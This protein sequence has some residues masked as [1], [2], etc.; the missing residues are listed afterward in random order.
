MAL[1]PRPLSLLR[2]RLP[3]A[4][5]GPRLGHTCSSIIYDVGN[6]NVDEKELQAKLRHEESGCGAITGRGFNG[7]IN[8]F[9]AAKF[10]LPTVLKAGCVERAI[11]SAG[12]PSIH[13]KSHGTHIFDGRDSVQDV[14]NSL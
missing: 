5:G 14:Y 1:A 13:C 10:N 11:K 7:A 9:P 6:W 8:G 12:G 2:R 4:R 3:L